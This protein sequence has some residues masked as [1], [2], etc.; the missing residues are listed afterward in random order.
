MKK[1]VCSVLL[2]LSILMSLALPT[3]A[4]EENAEPAARL[5]SAVKYTDGEETGIY[6]LTYN[7]AS[8]SL[9]SLVRYTSPSWSYESTYTYRED[10]R[11]LTY[12][13]ECLSIVQNTTDIYSYDDAGRLIQQVDTIETETFDGEGNSYGVL[14]YTTYYDYTY[15]DA[16][17]LV[18]RIDTDEYGTES[19]RYEYTYTDGEMTNEKYIWYDYSPDWTQ[20]ERVTEYIYTYDDE[21]RKATSERYD[22]GEQISASEY[23]YNGILYIVKSASGYVS[24]NLRNES[25]I[26]IMS[27]GTSS[28]EGEPE[29]IYDDAGRLARIETP[30][31]GTYIELTYESGSDASA[32]NS[33]PAPEVLSNVVMMDNEYCTLTL[34]NYI[35]STLY[36]SFANKSSESAHRLY[37]KSVS[38]NGVDVP[39]R[40]ITDVTDPEKTSQC[41]LYLEQAKLDELGISNI[42]NIT[43]TCYLERVEG[44]AYWPELSDLIAS[45]DFPAS[46]ATE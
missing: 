12:H 38:C 30:N 3:L 9:P 7:N 16:G 24:A 5:I 36:L 33:G 28:E 21:G 44:N 42:E 13:Q 19:G 18:S 15:N 14:P 17:E 11:V 4:A 25:G 35:G 29:L 26:Q 43:L 34:D 31:E 23:S 41:M 2:V 39:A 20:I 40:L 27:I 10:G 22:D 8:D 46:D 32:D 1:I 45:I 37:T 6:E